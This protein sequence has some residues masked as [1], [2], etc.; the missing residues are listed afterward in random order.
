[1]NPAILYFRYMLR[2]VSDNEW[3]FRLSLAQRVTNPLG[4]RIFTFMM[5]LILGHGAIAHRS[6]I[7][8]LFIGIIMITLCVCIIFWMI[9]LMRVASRNT[10]GVVVVYHDRFSINEGSGIYQ[11]RL[12]INAR[13]GVIETIPYTH[14]VKTSRGLAGCSLIGF[15]SGHTVVLP[16][17]IVDQIVY[18]KN[19]GPFLRDRSKMKTRFWGSGYLYGSQKGLGGLLLFFN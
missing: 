8:G 10:M 15:I 11:D 17:P 16:T 3:Q 12:D 4:L 6:E 13:A 9:K 18:Y 5:L 7:F 19:W 2:R 14:I 1:M